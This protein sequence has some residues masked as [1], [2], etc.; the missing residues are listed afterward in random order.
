[1]GLFENDTRREDY[2]RAI[3]DVAQNG[4]RANPRSLELARRAAKQ[5]GSMGNSANSA[6]NKHMLSK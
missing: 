5:A 2:E 1:V 3:N 4:Q 6:L